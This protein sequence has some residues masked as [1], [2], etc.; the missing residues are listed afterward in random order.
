MVVT[1]LLIARGIQNKILEAMA[2]G[3]K[4]VTTP[5]AIEGITIDDQEI[6]VTEKT[7]DFAQQV[8]TN[9][10]NTGDAYCSVVNRNFVEEK[11]SWSANLKRLTQIIESDIVKA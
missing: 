6:Y 8:V 10:N 3:K 11:Y 9:L 2:M 4:I 7:G 1:P 5:Q